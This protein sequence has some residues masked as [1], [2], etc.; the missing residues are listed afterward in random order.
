MLARRCVGSTA[1]TSGPSF[2][3]ETS[4]CESPFLLPQQTGIGGRMGVIPEPS[5]TVTHICV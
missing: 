2:E 4:N 1:G 5:L 3:S